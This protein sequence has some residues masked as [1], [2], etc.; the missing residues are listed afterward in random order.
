[1]VGEV[2]AGGFEKSMA[3]GF[4][5]A[6]NFIALISISLCLMNL[7]PLPILDGGMIILY[8]TEMII[9]KPIHPKAVSVFQ[10][11]G[12]VIIFGLMVF[13]I[14]NDILFFASQ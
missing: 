8:L 6:L 14:F 5:S 11:A 12:I 7:L 1:M 2:A 10:T 4:I 3:D 9:R 13:A